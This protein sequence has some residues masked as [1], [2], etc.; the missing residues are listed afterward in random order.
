MFFPVF[1]SIDWNPQ[2]SSEIA[3][4]KQSGHFGK[5]NNFLKDVSTSSRNTQVNVEKSAVDEN[6]MN[7]DELTAALFDDADE[8]ENSFSIRQVKISVKLNYILV[9][10][11][12]F[13]SFTQRRQKRYRKN[14]I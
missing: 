3:F 6:D 4:I 1:H 10:H 8:D 7:A 14:S 5:V 2:D 13:V 12:F 11:E 9:F